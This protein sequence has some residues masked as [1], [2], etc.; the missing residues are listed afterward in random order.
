MRVHRKVWLWWGKWWAVQ[1]QLPVTLSLG[2]R[3]EFSRPM[4]DFYVAS[5]TLSI[6]RHPAITDESVRHSD[7]CRGFLF[8]DDEV[9]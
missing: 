3:L 4:L 1:V 2:V 7:S 5:L 6:G 9:L 8:T